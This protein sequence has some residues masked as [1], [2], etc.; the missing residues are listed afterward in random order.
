MSLNTSRNFYGNTDTM[1]YKVMVL[2]A[3]AAVINL[4]VITILNFIYNYLA[5]YLTDIELR[6][7]QQEYDESLSLK[8]YLFQFVN[9]YSS[10]FYI[11]FLKGKFVGYPAKYNRVF[12]LRQE[13]CSP[14]GCLM[15]LCIQLV[16]I[17]VGKQALNAALEML[18]PFIMKTWN[19]ISNKIGLSKEGENGETLICCSQWTEDYKL[20][21]WP[22]RGLFEEY[23]EMII[24]YGFI[25]I[26]VVAF[27]LAPLFALINNVFEMR[28]DAKKMLRFYKRSVPQRI[29]DIGIWYG[30]MN[31]LGKIA[32]WSSAFIIAFST[33]FIP[34]LV[35]MS[36]IGQ[37]SDY[38]FL[39][40]TLAYF[41]TTDFQDGTAPL[42]TSFENVE[43]CRYAEFRNPPN[44]VSPLV[45]YKRPL[46]YWHIL[47]IRLAFI[48]VYQNVVGM[49]QMMVELAIPDVPRSLKDKMKREDYLTR[50]NII[51]QEKV[52]IIKK[53]DDEIEEE[54]EKEEVERKTNGGNGIVTH[55]R[56]TNETNF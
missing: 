49:V 20:L 8:I 41:N 15:E 25:T 47:A 16:I 24:Q 36:T 37:G 23:L 44:V 19:T 53:C 48:V 55:R 4:V 3:T 14:G 52:N 28:L 12:K 2:P 9:Y 45:K 50:E 29:K 11:A 27:P 31:I 13:E 35:Y 10:I 38:G 22:A 46:D 30:I 5:I 7:T 43:I 32:V 33:N 34:R 26:F 1:S 40:Y 21:D 54:E 51:E 39:N 18:I 56:K 6:R 17:M 42:N